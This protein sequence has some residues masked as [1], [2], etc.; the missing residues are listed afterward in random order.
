MGLMVSAQP[1]LMNYQGVARGH[2]GQVLSEQLI[3]LRIHIVS[4]EADG[5]IAYT[6]VH[7]VRTGGLGSFS[8]R[9]G[10]G[11]VLFGSFPDIPWARHNHFIRVEM[12]ADGGSRYTDMGTTQLLSVPYAFHA[13]TAGSL[14]F[15]P[16]DTGDSGD[17]A[18][19]NSN[20]PNNQGNNASNTGVAANTWSLFGNRRSD[21]DKDKL[22]T[23]DN[24]D[25]V[26]VT[27]NEERM[28]IMS[29]GTVII[30]E[31]LDIG[32]NLRVRGDEVIIDHDLHVGGI[33]HTRG[34][35]VKDDMPDG[36]FIATF[37]NTNED[38][39]DGI[40]IRLGRMRANNGL[41]VIGFSP[42]MSQDQMAQVRS[43]ISCELSMSQKTVVLAELVKDGIV[44]DAQTIAGMAVDV[45][46]HVRVFIND[47]IK[48]GHDI[49]PR[50][51]IFNGYRLRM[52]TIAGV[53]I[54]DVNVPA[55]R[56]GPWGLPAIP[57][58]NLTAF[59][60]P[61]VPVL[62]PAFWGV[63]NLC[64]DD[65]VSNPL[66]NDNEFIRFS[67]ADNQRMGAI[68]AE[69]VKDWA[70]NYLSVSFMM[71]LR[72]AYMSAVDKK[73]GKHHFKQQITQA[74]DAYKNI[75]VEYTSGNGDYAEWLER[76][77]HSEHI[78]PGDIV[79]VAGGK[80]TRDLSNA[81]QVMAVSHYP[82]VLGNVPEEGRIH[83]GNNI[84]FMGQIPVKIMGPV[85][86]G[87]Y[88]VGMGDIPGYGVAISPEQ[89]TVE[90]FRFAVGRAW[91]THSDRGP[92]MVNTVVGVHNGD[93]IHVLKS[94]ESRLKETENRLE[95]LEG[96]MGT[97]MGIVNDRP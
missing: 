47:K 40:N 55:I 22:G 21:P 27:N 92:K 43:L 63:P 73:H 80:I 78:S 2:D 70:D 48:L 18:K 37:E 88:I 35:V 42:D 54:P 64:L 74:V 87:D 31:G 89:M 24:V 45:G 38:K 95:A 19:N 39:G 41:E 62:D 57:E 93:Y 32:G 81:E 50:T 59:G 3:S 7:R 23:T 46:N 26:F 86:T 91:E 58:I 66:N 72:G 12:D 16:Y 69:S 83:L 34:L 11:E 4:G 15:D 85:S 20:N 61:A 51:Q 75:G 56:I 5:P 77:D 33:T 13:Q 29:D 60:I 79:A 94:Y 8:V 97:L 6:E 76:L 67:D 30:A 10:G 17:P 65:V 71:G 9:I 82:I 1:Q 44:E 84:A 14:V 25:L 49:V 96:K 28:R 52:P 68:R 36:G 90:D 53:G